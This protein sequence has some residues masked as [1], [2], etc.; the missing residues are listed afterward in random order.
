MNPDPAVRHERATRVSRLV[1]AP[2]AGDEVAG[3]GGLLA[4]YHADA[5]VVI[6]VEPDERRRVQLRTAQ[7]MLG[8]PAPTVLGLPDAPLADQVDRIVD[9]LAA[10][11]AQLRPT[12]IYV[13]YP[14]LQRDH[15][16]AYEAG[17]RSM[18]APTTR[19]V[20][21]SVSVLAYD[22][23][24]DD[25]DDHLADVLWT[26]GESLSEQD[27]DRLAAAAVAYRSPLARRLK[28]RA[29]EIGSSRGLPWAEQYAVV[30]MP[31]ERDHS[32]PAVAAMAGGAR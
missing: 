12:E 14:S 26:T 17:M 8:N 7:R 22:V 21:P 28:R 15:L 19:E 30:R 25:T 4:K 18:C 23:G 11:V 9:E 16:A 27:V 1:V 24:A 20:W 2:R 3:C 31:P 6:I 13:P 32:A 5:A 29:G 10:L